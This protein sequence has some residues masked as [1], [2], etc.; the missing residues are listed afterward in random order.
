MRTYKITKN[1]KDLKTG[2]TIE[3]ATNKL[4]PIVEDFSNGYIYDNDNETIY[5]E[6]DHKTIAEKGDMIVVAGDNVFEIVEE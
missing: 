5:H 4:F 6:V 1:S 3:E 2:L